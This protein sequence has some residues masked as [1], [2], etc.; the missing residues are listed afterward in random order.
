MPWV[1]VG[2]LAGADILL[3]V[4]V[5]CLIRAQDRLMRVI[6]SQ[7]RTEAEVPDKRKGHYSMYKAR[8][9]DT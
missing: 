3:S 1:I 4:A 5:V 2:V 7:Y 6:S 8:G 9:E